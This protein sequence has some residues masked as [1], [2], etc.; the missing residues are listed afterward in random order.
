MAKTSRSQHVGG[1]LEAP[2]SAPL[3]TPLEE[4]VD[5]LLA[6]LEPLERTPPSPYVYNPL[7]Y[8]RAPNREYLARYAQPSDARADRALLVGM[9]P[10]PYGMA[11]TGVPFGAVSMV[12]DWLRIEGPVERAIAEHPKR[13]V[14][15]FSCEREEV[16]G[17]R[18]WGWAR[19]R[20]GSPE[21][22]F[23]RFFVWNYCPLLFL[24]A[25]G[26]NLPPDK[27]PA[28]V[29][30]A[31]DEPCERA[32]RRLV[33][34]LSFR[35]VVGVGGFA[36]A[37]ARSALAPSRASD[38]I[39]I[40]RILHPSPASPAANR[41][42]AQQAEQQLAELGIKALLRTSEAPPQTEQQHRGGPR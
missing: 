21:R 41:G 27:L 20:F 33:E 9:N 29:R 37:R 40:G 30:R 39:T 22:F 4:I 16:S 14:L 26:R 3:A 2:L 6:A 42:W 19:D 28:A 11:Q 18:L 17:A 35:Y 10:G 23:P 25:S 12:R 32:L 5:E 8:A 36:E 38:A 24:E 1:P 13:P 7:R 34:T 31:L 15:G